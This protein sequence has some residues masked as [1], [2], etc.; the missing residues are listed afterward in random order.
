[1]IRVPESLLLFAVGVLSAFIPGLPEPNIDP[2]LILTLFLPPLIYAS[3]VRV[4][5]H[6]LRFTLVPGVVLGT[7]L[8]L[9]TIG[10]VVVAAR[11]VF[12][13]DLSWTAAVLIGIVAS[14]FDTGLFHEAE[15][16]PRVPR[17]IADTLKAREL[18]GRI[19]ILAT[20]SVVEEALPS[21]EVAAGSILA[22][23][24]LDIPAGALVGLAVGQAAASP[25]P[26]RKCRRLPELFGAVRG[27]GA[28]VWTPQG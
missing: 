22:N 16:R 8:A 20:L 23:Y 19:F 13:S 10:A 4:S 24:V 17:A 18:V 3:T 27:R 14:I 26:Q 6:L 21:R 7:I 9:T 28:P 25:T 1:M 15:G 12:L 11:T 5:W 2:D